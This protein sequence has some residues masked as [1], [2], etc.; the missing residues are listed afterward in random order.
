MV[1]SHM[2]QLLA[3]VAM[4]VP[5]RMD[6]QAIRNEKVT[7]LQAVAAMTGEQV[8]QRTVRGQYAAAGD[9][10]GYRQEQGVA[11]DSEVETYAAL[12]LYVDTWR[13]SG[14][15]FHLRTGKALAAKTSQIVLVFKREPINLF[16]LFGK[17][18]CDVRGPNRLIIR[19]TPDEGMSLI[20][21]G[22]VPGVEMLLRPMKLDFSYGPSFVS[23]SP[24][25]YE[26]L[27]LDAI[28]GDPTLFL[29]NDEVE[30][31]WRIV[32]A[33]RASWNAT[34]LP[35]L[36]MYPAGSQGPEQARGLLGD[37]YKDWYPL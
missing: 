16:N 6:A 3:L 17:V 10:I 26:H 22:K 27:L 23:A 35:K 18:G 28:T 33:I 31:S 34:G 20:I 21:D 5:P 1:Q 12:T 19:I 36:I 14:V 37:P 29:R 7:V 4:D 2:L 9:R 24:E 25:A 15:P 8:A 32:D 11:P 30:A 13:W